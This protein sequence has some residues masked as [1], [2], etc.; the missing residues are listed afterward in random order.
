MQR[1]A[2]GGDRACKTNDEKTGGNIKNILFFL[3]DE[4]L[5]IIWRLFD[6]VL[7]VEW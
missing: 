4:E 2:H 7:M 5:K 3:L 1:A 6:L